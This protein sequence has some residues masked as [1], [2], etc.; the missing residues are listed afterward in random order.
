MAVLNILFYFVIDFSDEL[1]LEEEAIWITTIFWPIFIVPFSIMVIRIFAKKLTK[2]KFTQKH[3]IEKIWLKAF[4]KRTVTN[5]SKEDTTQ[6][7]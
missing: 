1:E 7:R 2:L 5:G 4:K 3:W 6:E